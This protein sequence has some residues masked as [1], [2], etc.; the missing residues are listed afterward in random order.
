MLEKKVHRPITK[1]VQSEG[2]QSYVFPSIFK[3]FCKI[4]DQFGY[5]FFV[6]FIILVETK[7]NIQGK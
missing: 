2:A 7:G 6:S 4:L 3:Q 5:Q 1:L